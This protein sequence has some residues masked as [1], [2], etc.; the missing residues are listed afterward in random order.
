MQFHRNL[1]SLNLNIDELAQTKLTMSKVASL[2]AQKFS[3]GKPEQAPVEEEDLEPAQ[4]LYKSLVQHNE[5]N[6]LNLIKSIE[7]RVHEDVIK[8]FCKEADHSPMYM[9]RIHLHQFLHNYQKC[10]QMFF[11]IKVIKA[12][13]FQWLQDIAATIPPTYNGENTSE[14]LQQLILKNIGSFIDM[15]PQKTVQLCDQ[16]FERNYSRMVDSIYKYTPSRTRA[17]ELAFSF[18]NTVLEMHEKSIIEEYRIQTFYTAADEMNSAAANVRAQNQDKFKKLIIDL[19]KILCKR[20][21]RKYAMEYMQR[22]YFPIEECLKIC[23]DKGIMD[24]CAILYRRKGDFDKAIRQYIQVLT[25]L[26]KRSVISELY[27]TADIPFNDPNT[28]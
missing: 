21:Y 24:A 16:W 26:S 14:Q 20:N 2:A 8:G 25:R 9:V 28:K 22:D 10:L 18:I 23:E 6:V 17:Y 7:Y 13:V 15:N 27:L 1:L 12:H 4:R 19:T 3:F 11:K 5:A